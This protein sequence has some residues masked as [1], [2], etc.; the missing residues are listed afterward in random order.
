M[1]IIKVSDVDIIQINGTTTTVGA[2]S[3]DDP[4]VWEMPTSV[5]FMALELANKAKERWD[6]RHAVLPFEGRSRRH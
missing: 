4:V 6:K 3:G 5:F 1:A 2:R